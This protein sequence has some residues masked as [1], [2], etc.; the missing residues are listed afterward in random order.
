MTALPTLI[1]ADVHP[2]VPGPATLLPYMNEHWAEYWTHGGLPITTFYNVYPPK[3][4]TTGP[5]T[6]VESVV[7]TVLRDQNTLA[8]L[9][10]YWA[11]EQPRHPDFSAALA[12]AVNNWVA[13][14]WLDREPR[15]RASI[16][17]PRD[18][19]LA[20]AEIERLG[21]H[22]GFV[23]VLLPVR[24]E[25]PYGHRSFFPVL[26]AAVRHKLPVALHAGGLPGIPSTANGWPVYYIEEYV[27]MATVF[28]SQVAS[29][30]ASGVFERLP[31]LRIVLSEGGFGWLPPLMWRLTKEWKGLRR[32]IPWVKRLPWEYIRDHM[33]ATLAP[34]DVPY[35]SLD[36]LL[37]QI[38]SDKFLLYAS[39]FPHLHHDDADDSRPTSIQLL[40][41]VGGELATR[42]AATNARELYDF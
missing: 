13:A 21:Q 40:E 42:I 34:I 18:V 9:N 3:V 8:V 20:V 5:P 26:E 41:T 32:E 16:A 30:V 36:R 25:R 28:Q 7:N 35:S 19:D 24:A 33:R 14:E 4:P 15:F 39:D 31:E 27:G 1:D 22:P 29:L 37:E 11:V 17:V 38:G 6:T 10:C 2:V 23:Q 12:A